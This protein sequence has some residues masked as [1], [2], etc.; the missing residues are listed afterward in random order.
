[1]TGNKYKV[2][3]AADRRWEGRTYGSKAEMQYAQQLWQLRKMGEI[4]EY[5]EQPRLWLGVP[6]NVYIPDFFV[7]SECGVCWYVDVK[8]METQKFKRDKKLWRAYGRHSLHL[9]KKS[10]KGF[11]VYETIDSPTEGNG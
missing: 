7:V 10:G 11:K 4:V 3:P 8:G 9:V 6:E 5:I 2:S 1:M